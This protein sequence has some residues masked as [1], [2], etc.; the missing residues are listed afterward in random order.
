MFYNLFIIL[1]TI[2]FISYLIYS[3]LKKRD[4]FKNGIYDIGTCY[5]NNKTKYYFRMERRH[6]RY[7]D[8]RK[9]SE[10]SISTIPN[11]LGVIL[12][13]TYNDY[14]SAQASLQKFKRKINI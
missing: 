11:E 9:L 8:A 2:C 13:N 6:G 3:Y 7:I 14:E 1:I 12:T 5:K 4:R 10:K